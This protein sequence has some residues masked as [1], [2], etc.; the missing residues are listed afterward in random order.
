MNNLDIVVCA[1]ALEF[2]HSLPPQSNDPECVISA[3]QRFNQSDPYAPV[4]VKPG[5]VQTSLFDGVQE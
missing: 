1:D 2:M 3:T 4:I 5:I